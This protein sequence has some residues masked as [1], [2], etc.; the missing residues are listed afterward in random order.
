MTKDMKEIQQLS[1]DIGCGVC[2]ARDLLLLA[3]G[4][5]HLVHKASKSGDNVESVK[6]YILNERLTRLERR[7]NNGQ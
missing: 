4:D 1:E 6:T 3:D 5:V 7:V 2:L